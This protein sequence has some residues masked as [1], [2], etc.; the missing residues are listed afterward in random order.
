MN[1]CNLNVSFFT[2]IDL[3]YL[4]TGAGVGTQTKTTNQTKCTPG[5][6]TYEEGTYKECEKP[7]VQSSSLSELC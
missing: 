2:E 5:I 3:Y 7:V 1:I 4:L 6:E